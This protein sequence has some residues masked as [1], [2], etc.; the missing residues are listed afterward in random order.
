MVPFI[1]WKWWW[2][3]RLWILSCLLIPTIIGAVAEYNNNEDPEED[4]LLVLIANAKS[5]NIVR[6]KERG[7]NS[8]NDP[9][10]RIV[11]NLVG[12]D[13]IRWHKELLYVSVKSNIWVMPMSK[14]EMAASD[15]RRP[16]N[17][18]KK[19]WYLLKPR[20][21][22]ENNI[23][24]LESVLGFDFHDRHIYVSSFHTDEILKYDQETG[25]FLEVFA[26]GD[27][28]EEGLINGPGRIAIHEDKLY[29]TTTGLAG[30]GIPDQGLL[31][32]QIIV[33]DI[34]SRMGSVF[35]RPAPPPEATSLAVSMYG[36]EIYCHNKQEE[37]G[38]VD[39][40]MN[41][42]S[43]CYLY[44][45]DLGGWLHAYRLGDASLLYQASTTYEVGARTADLAVSRDVVYVTGFAG[46]GGGVVHRFS[47]T[48]GSP[49]PSVS[50]SADPTNIGTS[51]AEALMFPPSLDLVQPT[52]IIAIWVSSGESDEKS[53]KGGKG[54]KKIASRKSRRK[55]TRRMLKMNTLVVKWKAV[56]R[57]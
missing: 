17:A 1:R 18:R 33:F 28:T 34:E 5:D 49:L 35:V 43:L 7:M 26:S 12:P 39:T 20:F 3:L 29:V 53:G 24:N 48:D 31:H 10:E 30:G 4:R 56:G 41:D 14:S 23:K 2:S 37:D 55:T 8:D 50:L 22:A 25:E 11:S 36:V 19:G 21:D 57:E 44:A 52:G 45:T 54:G 42:S 47:A 6:Y 27:R 16:L 9:F 40:D 51:S 15:I 38:N 46:T 13:E 32:S